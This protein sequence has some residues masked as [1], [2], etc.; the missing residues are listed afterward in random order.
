MIAENHQER[1]DKSLGSFFYNAPYG[2]FRTL[3]L[4][5]NLAVVIHHL[6]GCHGTFVAFVA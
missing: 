1:F 2:D 3:S 5:F 4:S 6:D